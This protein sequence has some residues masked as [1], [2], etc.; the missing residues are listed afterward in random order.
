MKKVKTK[1]KK[2]RK[3]LDWAKIIKLKKKNIRITAYKKLKKWLYKNPKF[4]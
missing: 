2:A 4:Y 3:V 1:I